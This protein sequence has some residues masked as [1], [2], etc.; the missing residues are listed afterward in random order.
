MRSAAFLATLSSDVVGSDST[1]LDYI[2]FDREVYDYGNNYNPGT[3]VYRVPY[4][5]MYLIHARVYG[6]NNHASHH[7]MVCRVKVKFALL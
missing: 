4:D 7:V 5:G 2:T 6:K 3:G 1:H